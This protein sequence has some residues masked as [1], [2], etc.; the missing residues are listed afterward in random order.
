M[1]D[2]L[3]AC[4][5]LDRAEHA[6][7]AAGNQP[8]MTFERNRGLQVG[9]RAKLMN[10][11]QAGYAL[12]DA[13][14]AYQLGGW[15]GRSPWVAWA[16]SLE[17]SDTP[18]R[19]LARIL[20]IRLR[21]PRHIAAVH[22]QG[23]P[24]PVFILGG[25]SASFVR[26]PDPEPAVELELLSAAVAA[27]RSVGGHVHKDPGPVIGLM[28]SELSHRA[29]RCDI[30]AARTFSRLIQRYGLQTEPV[31]RITPAVVALLDAISA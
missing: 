25:G 2:F 24:A 26:R 13:I 3:E 17:S 23:W 22:P 27:M 31:S 14:G 6:N 29:V 9:A 4:G 1:E 19:A 15:Q 28:S 20:T 12:L 30:A 21:E 5:D 7:V 11:F 10:Y 18:H 8:D 16:A